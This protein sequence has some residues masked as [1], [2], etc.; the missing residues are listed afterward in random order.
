MNIRMARIGKIHNLVKFEFLTNFTKKIVQFC[1]SETDT[2]NQLKENRLGFYFLEKEVG[3]LLLVI[4][5]Y[6]YIFNYNAVL[7]CWH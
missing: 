1:S 4:S 2:S 3:T 5:M 7:L 6:I